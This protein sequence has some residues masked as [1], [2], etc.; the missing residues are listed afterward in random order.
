MV[1]IT[2][3]LAA[4]IGTFVLGL[5]DNIQTNVQAGA[6]VSSDAEN[7][8]VTVTY[9]SA[10]TDGAE[11]NVTYTP[12]GGTAIQADLTSIGQSDTQSFTD[13]DRVRVVVT[14]KAN[15]AST[16]IVQDTVQL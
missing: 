12:I 13:G 7:D 1:A 14:A 15:G 5:G 2:V 6:S 9:T 4:V 10:Q 8:E 16:V 11:L 3:I